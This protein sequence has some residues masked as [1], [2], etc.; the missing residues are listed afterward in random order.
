[1]IV[2]KRERLNRGKRIDTRKV[3][4]EKSEKSGPFDENHVWLNNLTSECRIEM[5]QV[6]A[7]DTRPGQL[8]CTTVYAK[9]SIHQS[10]DGMTVFRQIVNNKCNEDTWTLKQGLD[11][12]FWVNL[13]VKSRI[14][15]NG[16]G[17]VEPTPGQ[18]S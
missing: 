3:I 16:Q 6:L 8:V 14:I 18:G 5:I 12:V 15:Q 17:K 10:V 11:S 9:R 2:S 1:M 13:S 4:P 7:D